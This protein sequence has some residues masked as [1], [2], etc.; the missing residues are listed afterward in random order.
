MPNFD[1]CS[2]CKTCNTIKVDDMTTREEDGDEIIT[3]KHVCSNCQHEIA[4]HQ[5]I[6]RV[7]GQFQVY[8]M[9]CLLCGNGEDER[10]IMPYD[11]RGPHL[12]IF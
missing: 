11:P 6:F 2:Q 3:Y 5:H 9:T 10:S 7:D 8:E 1:G 4:E 12:E